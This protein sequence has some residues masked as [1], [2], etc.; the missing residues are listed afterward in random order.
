MGSKQEIKTMGKIIRIFLIILLC[1]LI[2]VL[3]SSPIMLTACLVAYVDHRFIYSLIITVPMS[4]YMVV[5]VLTAKW[6]N[7]L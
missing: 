5:G 4:A 2:A 7:E 1:C 3:V 6:F